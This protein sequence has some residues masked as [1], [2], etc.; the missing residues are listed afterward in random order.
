MALNSSNT[1][2][3]SHNPVIEP[4]ETRPVSLDLASQQNNAEAL[5]N[6]GFKGF[7]K[8]ARRFV[9]RALVAAAPLVLGSCVGETDMSEQDEMQSYS[10]VGG[11]PAEAPVESVSWRDRQVML[12][13]D[14]KDWHFE[15]KFPKDFH[16]T[17]DVDGKRVFDQQVASTNGAFNVKGLA[18]ES[19]KDIKIQAF[20]P[21]GTDMQSFKIPIE[22]NIQTKGMYGVD[23]FHN[24]EY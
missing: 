13:Y 16:L 24:V 9:T 20:D 1:S 3:E 4:A 2:P 12:N 7:L 15:G 19:V 10:N 22:P 14:G 21:N 6:Q 17:V 18:G 8:S 5:K 11:A 23:H